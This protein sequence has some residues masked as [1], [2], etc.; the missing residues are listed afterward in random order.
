MDKNTDKS[1]RP[2]LMSRIKKDYSFPDND[3]VVDAMMEAIAITVDRGYMEMQPI[4]EK[5]SDLICPWCG[6]LH[7][8]QDCQKQFEKYEQER[9]GQHEPK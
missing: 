7:F 3:P 4:M 9:K 8:R 6:K 2:A 1:N 5:Y